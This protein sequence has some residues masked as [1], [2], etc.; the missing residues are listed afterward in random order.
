MF[1]VG[2]QY[3]L[4]I[5]EKYELYL[6]YLEFYCRYILHILKN[7]DLYLIPYDLHNSH[8]V[9]VDIHVDFISM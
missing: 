4:T 2:K 9:G 5:F 8:C 3:I 1:I 6:R 7:M